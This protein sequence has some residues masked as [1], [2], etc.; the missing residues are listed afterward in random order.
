MGV[1]KHGFSSL[2]AEE[3]ESSKEQR[4]EKGKEEGNTAQGR[5]FETTVAQEIFSAVARIYQPEKRRDNL[6]HQQV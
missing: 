3:P 1:P 2:S 6:N 4:K 5:S